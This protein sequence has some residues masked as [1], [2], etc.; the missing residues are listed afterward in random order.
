MQSEIATEDSGTQTAYS[1]GRI[2]ALLDKH[3]P[4]AMIYV[5]AA[6]ILGVFEW[7]T[8]NAPGVCG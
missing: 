5:I 2:L 3:G 4:K 6:Q 7:L 1:A 8:A